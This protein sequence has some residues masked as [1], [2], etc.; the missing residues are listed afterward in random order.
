[1]SGGGGGGAYKRKLKEQQFN[2]QIRALQRDDPG[3]EAHKKYKCATFTAVV[4][5]GIVYSVA[6]GLFIMFLYRN[7]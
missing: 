6:L 1:M 7:L 3:A 5:T 4:F 2:A